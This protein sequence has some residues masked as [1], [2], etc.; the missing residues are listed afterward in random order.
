MRMQCEPSPAAGQAAGPRWLVQLP[1]HQQRTRR[2]PRRAPRSC[3]WRRGSRGPA[4]RGRRGWLIR[5]NIQHMIHNRCQVHE[6]I[7]ISMSHLSQNYALSAGLY[8]TMKR[9]LTYMHMIKLYTSKVAC[10]N[11]VIAAPLDAPLGRAP[12]CHR[13]RPMRRACPPQPTGPVRRGSG[14]NVG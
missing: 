7:S 5:Y 9:S 2:C 1:P 11:R 14:V 12:R 8:V 4:G 6:S 13:R 10:G 3:T